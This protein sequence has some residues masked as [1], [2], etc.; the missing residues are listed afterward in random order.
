MILLTYISMQR[1]LRLVRC[2][3]R[4]KLFDFSFPSLLAIDPSYFSRH[5]RD[6]ALLRNS[7]CNISISRIWFV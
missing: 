3:V 4:L 1:I 5:D 7:V 2:L 6:N